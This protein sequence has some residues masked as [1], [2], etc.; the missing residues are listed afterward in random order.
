MVNKIVGNRFET[1]LSRT[2]GEHGFW[3]H[4]MQQNKAGQPADVIAV[5][6]SYHTLIDCKVISGERATFPFSRVEENQRY[7]MTRFQ[8]RGGHVCWF[9][10]KMPGGEIRMLSLCAIMRLEKKGKKSLS[11]D[12]LERWTNTLDQWLNYAEVESR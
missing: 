1:E 9:A 12:E 11:G 2:L 10:L 3:C 7:A 4:V 8:E 6:R 5:K